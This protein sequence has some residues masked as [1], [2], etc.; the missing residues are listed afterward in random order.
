MSDAPFVGAGE[1]AAARLRAAAAGA[2]AARRT[3]IDVLRVG[4]T[5]GIGAGKSAVAGLLAGHG[6]IVVDADAIAR[7]VVEPGSGGLGAVLA[8]FGAGVCGPDGRL[9]RAGLASI[10]FADPDARR[11]LN[12]IVHP[13]VA[14]RTA[15]LLADAPAD[16]VLV[17]DVPLLAENG[18]AGHY[19]LVLVVEAP[20]DARLA[21]LA[22]RGMPADEA[23][24]RMAAQASDAD[25]RA[26]ADVVIGNSGTLDELAAAVDAVWRDRIVP[27]TS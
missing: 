24:A 4:L 3:V 2:G 17:H 5:G 6:A 18:L 11:R 26:V 8:E 10:V 7:E 1:A 9:D 13:L 21:R 14:E 19:D 15:Q 16:S 22:A 20:Q 25:R 12:A 23:R 27:L